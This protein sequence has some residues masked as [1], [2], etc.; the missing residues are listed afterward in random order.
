M[1]SHVALAA[2]PNLKQQCDHS[3]SV[4]EPVPFRL[5]VI[6]VLNLQYFEAILALNQQLQVEI[7][8]TSGTIDQVSDQQSERLDAS[9]V[10]IVS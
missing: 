3:D 7:S 5:V 6:G 4:V 2:L 1:P 8:A 9:Y 10:V